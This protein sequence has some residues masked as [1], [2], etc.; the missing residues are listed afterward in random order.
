LDDLRRRGNSSG[1]GTVAQGIDR[2]GR[3]KAAPH[4]DELER[5]DERQRDEIGEERKVGEE[6][7]H[8]RHPRTI[9]IRL[10]RE[11]EKSEG[12]TIRRLLSRE[13]E[14]ERERE[15]GVEERCTVR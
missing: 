8:A 15:S 2:G 7:L 14:G 5:D 9:R 11:K 6:E 10:Q 12:V 13:R 1:Q 3:G 4:L